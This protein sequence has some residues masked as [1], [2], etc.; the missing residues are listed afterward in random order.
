MLLAIEC[1]EHIARFHIHAL[2]DFARPDVDDQGFTAHNEREQLNKTLLSLMEFY[3]LCAFRNIHC[4]N[5]AEFRAYNIIMH[6]HDQD[7]ER[8]AMNLGRQR[9]QLFAHPRIQKALELYAA[10]GNTHDLHGPL[11]PHGSNPVAQNNVGK[12]FRLVSSSQISYTMA[13]VAEIHF[14]HIRKNALT[15]IRAAYKSPVTMQDCSLAHLTDMLGFDY[16]DQTWAFCEAC[17]MEVNEGKDGEPYLVL[18]SGPDPLIDPSGSLKQPF[19][20]RV[21]EHKRHGRTLPH[22]INGLTVRQARATGETMAEPV[23]SSPS[24]PSSA[25]TQAPVGGA[26]LTP[27]PAPNFNFNTT[28][29]SSFG[30]PSFTPSQPETK[31]TSG[32]GPATLSLPF[33]NPFGTPQPTDPT[34]SNIGLSTISSTPATGSGSPIFGL[35]ASA[36]PK[37]PFSNFGNPTENEL[38]PTATQS[39]ASTSSTPATTL[40]LPKSF[41][42]GN[43][44]A[45]SFGNN[46]PASPSTFATPSVPQ[47]NDESAQP[48]PSIFGT[49][50]ASSTTTPFAPSTSL[51]PAAPS[52]DFSSADSSAPAPPKPIFPSMPPQ[53]ESTRS[54]SPFKFLNDTTAAPP[55]KP[56]DAASSTSNGP[57]PRVPPNTVEKPLVQTSKKQSLFF[58]DDSDEDTQMPAAPMET[59]SPPR[60]TPTTFFPQLSSTAESDK[61]ARAPVKPTDPAANRLKPSSQTSAKL[62]HP[63]KPPVKPPEVPERIVHWI[64]CGEGGLLDDFVE[65][66]LPEIV[67]D[68]FEECEEEKAV[69]FRR[70]KIMERYFYRWKYAAQ[71]RGMMER[72][73]QS[74]HRMSAL[75]SEQ[76]RKKRRSDSDTASLFSNDSFIPPAKPRPQPAVEPPQ[77]QHK[78]SRTMPNAA[79][80][81][82][83]KQHKQ[84][85]LRSRPRQSLRRGSNASSTSSFGSSFLSGASILS[86]SILS[87]ARSAI[88]KAGAGGDTIRSDYWRLKAAGLKTLPNGVTLP[89]S[90]ISDNKSQ[91][92]R[93][94]DADD[95]GVEQA[96]HS[97]SNRQP[98]RLL[99]PSRSV[100]ATQP[101]LTPRRTTNGHASPS[102]KAAPAP[103]TAI[104]LDSD[105][106]SDKDTTAARAPAIVVDS[107]DDPGDADEDDHLFAQL[108]ELR[109]AMDEGIDFYRREVGKAG[110]AWSVA[111]ASVAGTVDE[112]DDSEHEQTGRWLG[113]LGRA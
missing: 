96:R 25:S 83:P 39:V 2:H 99:T 70:R 11:K 80:L 40:D 67:M 6:F 15:A 113:S 109:N 27:Q 101:S 69:E 22:V 23:H 37:N 92:K 89:L 61:G 81:A 88:G 105:S 49:S 60:F 71:R 53:L 93:A 84:S 1:Y 32:P 106:E 41:T 78:R 63:Q 47:P 4:D 55:S 44:S 30:K 24:H 9:P 72:G 51:N 100:A 58:T 76:H 79:S 46:T 45:L 38:S 112:T 68:A 50:G 12:F 75:I 10:V 91:R 13:C 43:P 94:L 21:V 111:S 102:T 103:P 95:D 98:K 66:S 107:D 110:E 54:T 8:E 35:P 7:I 97:P 29:F 64:L 90:M 5:E 26:A 36:P 20:Q 104:N 52:F 87:G 3:H 16:E 42:F 73:R 62:S 17:G 56:F 77:S 14:N 57:T 28:A 59:S 34:S 86:P 33:G 48:P 74:R 31:P 65:Y 82:A 18:T 19:S 108:R 85:P